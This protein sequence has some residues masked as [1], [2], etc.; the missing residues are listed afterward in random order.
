MCSILC[1]AMWRQQEGLEGPPALGPFQAGGGQA[2]RAESEC[3][4]E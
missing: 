1:W 3:D 4:M 2:T